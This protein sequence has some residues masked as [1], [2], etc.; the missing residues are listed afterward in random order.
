MND[1][2]NHHNLSE[3]DRKIK[4]ILFY[5]KKIHRNSTCSNIME[6]MYPNV[7]FTVSQIAS[8]I[9]KPHLYTKKIVLQMQSDGYLLHD[10]KRYNR[11]YHLSETGRWFAVCVKLD[12]ITFQSLCI[13]SH[14]YYKVKP[15]PKSKTNCYMI[16]KFRDTFDKSHDDEDRACAS[17]VYTSRNISQSIRILVDRNLIYWANEDF[18]RISP[19]IFE[20]L[21]RYDKDLES[22]VSWQNRMFEK[23]R[24]QQLRTIMN[25]SE[26]RNLFSSIGQIHDNLKGPL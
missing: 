21:Q 20:N 10:K 9:N 19:G 12:Y 8:R 3:L 5:G 1:A 2:P 25:I 16:S 6:M 14:T 11:E 26:K 18:V 24:K 17:A 7:R 13:L 23:C 22:L 4:R 15:D